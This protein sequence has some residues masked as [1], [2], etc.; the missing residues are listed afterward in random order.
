[1]Y[2]KWNLVT[3]V[4]Y[5]A[6]FKY[7]KTFSFVIGYKNDPESMSYRLKILSKLFY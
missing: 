6:T 2:I 7:K 1:M 3:T 5:Y 4:L